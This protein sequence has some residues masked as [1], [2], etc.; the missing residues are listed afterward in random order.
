MRTAELPFAGP[1]GRGRSD[2]HLGIKVALII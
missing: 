1:K 2:V